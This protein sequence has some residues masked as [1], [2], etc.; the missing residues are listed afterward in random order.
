[1]SGFYDLHQNGVEMFWG[2]IPPSEHLLQIYDSEQV[3]LDTLEGFVTGGLRSGDGVIVIATTD[4]LDRLEERMLT[5]GFDLEAAR[6]SRQLTALRAEDVLAQFVVDGWPD[7]ALFQRV[8]RGLLSRARGTG[9]RVR[10]F[11][12]MVAILWERGDQGATVRLEFLWHQLC[13]TEGFSLFCAYPR[14]GFTGDSADTIN[15]L[16]ALHSRVIPGVRMPTPRRGE[17]RAFTP[18]AR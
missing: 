8:V 17:R 13:L 6:D 7:E 14:V 5:T 2:E 1:M 9:R 15:E 3:F 4:H 16:C 12:E 18:P 11:G 10:A